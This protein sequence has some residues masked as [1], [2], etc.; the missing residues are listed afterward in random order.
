MVTLREAAPHFL[1]QII[2][3]KSTELSK[4]NTSNRNM[5]LIFPPLNWGRSYGVRRSDLIY[6]RLRRIFFRVI[7]AFSIS[8]VPM[9]SQAQTNY[10]EL[11]QEVQ[12]IL[13]DRCASCH[14]P[15]MTRRTARPDKGVAGRTPINLREEQF[16]WL[17]PGNAAASELMA[18]IQLDDRG[19]A[20]MPEPP[21]PSLTP[22]EIN[23]V[24]D[25][26]DC[27]PSG[28]EAEDNPAEYADLQCKLSE[29]KQLDN[30]QQTGPAL[31]HV[32]LLE[33]Y[34]DIE[35]D[36]E[37]RLFNDPALANVRY[38]TLA[39]LANS[40]EY[41]AA[42]LDVARAALA[43]G[44]NSVSSAPRLARFVPI[45]E[46][47]LTYR[48][49]LNDLNW[50]VYLWDALM[51][52]NPYRGFPA[53]ISTDELLS[54]VT[55]LAREV[56]S[57]DIL[58]RGDW[59]LR[60][61]THPGR[62][63]A[64]LRM[65]S[66]LNGLEAFDNNDGKLHLGIDT[67]RSLA[68]NQLIRGGFQSDDEPFEAYNLE[69]N[70]V[71]SRDSGVSGAARVIER[72]DIGEYEGYFWKSYDFRQNSSGSVAVPV[73]P[74]D[75]VLQ[76]LLMELRQVEA[77]N[78]EAFEHDGGEMIFS[79][80]NGLQGYWIT[81]A[82]GA[83]LD[84]A[85]HDIVNWSY[86]NEEV[87]DSVPGRRWEFNE[88]GLFPGETNI[89]SDGIYNG[90]SC[91]SC[92]TQGMRLNSDFTGAY[93]SQSR[94]RLQPHL[95]T[96]TEQE[97]ILRIY[98]DDRLSSAL[99]DDKESFRRAVL[100]AYADIGLN[101]NSDGWDRL[102]DPDHNLRDIDP[103]TEVVSR[104]VFGFELNRQGNRPSSEELLNK[105]ANEL[106]LSPV[107]LQ[108]FL[109]RGGFPTLQN[110]INDRSLSRE[111]GRFDQSGQRTFECEFGAIARGMAWAHTNLDLVNRLGSGESICTE[112]TGTIQQSGAIWNN[113][114]SNPSSQ[115]DS[116]ANNGSAPNQ[117]A[118]ELTL[119]LSK[120]SLLPGGSFDMTIATDTTCELWLLDL[121]PD[122]GVP[123]VIRPGKRLPNSNR[124]GEDLLGTVL[125]SGE[126][127]V[128]RGVGAEFKA[129]L[130]EIGALCSIGGAREVGLTEELALAFFRK[131]TKA[132]QELELSF[133][134]A[135]SSFSQGLKIVSPSG[136]PTTKASDLD[137]QR[138][139]IRG[140]QLLSRT[141]L[142]NRVAITIA[143]FQVL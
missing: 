142:S 75:P 125:R 90:L 82:D 63:D 35:V 79:L 9:G 54:S 133:G 33:I 74:F 76:E 132:E 17:Q 28:M 99:S 128:I 141:A 102:V 115:A 108:L 113:D 11:D 84:A 73:Q 26:I 107:V 92:H 18:L 39:N 51:A 38:V 56:G 60:V 137:G 129:G 43:R 143:Q 50:D 4:N 48:I 44:L 14:H 124:M 57:Q 116:Y 77:F 2:C 100:Q 114:Q 81:T 61:A 86:S 131:K 97:A 40:G 15:D 23:T 25:W 135:T 121:D 59:L 49:Y 62:Y 22:T 117:A 19:Q 89:R 34:E 72:Q 67:R 3:T 13:L 123:T 87:A 1:H 37:D 127:L 140:A 47:H 66:D 27:M 78:L 52:E 106:W 20:D 93:F 88:I 105:V 5:I 91:M 122:S 30:Q 31:R 85:P 80:P 71:L 65:P 42:D 7:G 68:N 95:P 83:T 138:L 103:V 6:W 139:M 45:D 58:V 70:I 94:A 16:L 120:T 119:S 32:S 111:F 126:P 109:D 36:I 21:T 8:M 41:T 134:S 64:L 118:P 53:D 29:T 46:Q 101:E 98:N 10:F 110:A 112:N 24:S 55:R 130:K 104:Y 136:V 69:G 96:P 12:R